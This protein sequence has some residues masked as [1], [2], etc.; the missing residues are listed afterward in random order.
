MTAWILFA[1]LGLVVLLVAWP[2][3]LAGQ[4]YRLEGDLIAGLLAARARGDLDEVAEWEQM[5]DRFY[6]EHP[7]LAIE[8][9][10]S[11]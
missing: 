7:G 3:W 11:G 4:M 1:I 10:V 5:R 8:R 9:G 6:A 2:A